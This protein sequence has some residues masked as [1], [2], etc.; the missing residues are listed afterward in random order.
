MQEWYCHTLETG[1]V[2][3]VHAARAHLGKQ[4]PGLYSDLWI[5]YLATIVSSDE[6]VF[7]GYRDLIWDMMLGVEV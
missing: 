2:F 4:D 5:A 1:Q 3:K 7:P 6:C